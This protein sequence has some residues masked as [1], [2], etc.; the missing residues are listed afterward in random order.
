MTKIRHVGEN[1]VF[2]N[3]AFSRVSTD[4]MTKLRHVSFFLIASNEDGYTTNNRQQS[5]DGMDVLK[6][7]EKC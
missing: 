2:T 5:S 1:N 3:L 7:F 6:R 4:G